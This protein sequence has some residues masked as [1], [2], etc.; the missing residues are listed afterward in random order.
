MIQ[1]ECKF[2]PS[3]H[4]QEVIAKNFGVNPTLICKTILLKRT[5]N[6]QDRHYYLMM[7]RKTF[8]YVVKVVWV[9]IYWRG[10]GIY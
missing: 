7:L 2:Y 10:R 4:I 1:N 9:R 6:K 5:C 3:A 8:Y